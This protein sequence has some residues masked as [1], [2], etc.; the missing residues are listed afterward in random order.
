[1]KKDEGIVDAARECR[2]LQ[3]CHSHYERA[4]MILPNAK[5]TAVKYFTQICEIAPV[6]TPIHQAARAQLAKL[7]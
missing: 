1:M 7:Q 2:Q 3:W 5:E 6:D 4:E